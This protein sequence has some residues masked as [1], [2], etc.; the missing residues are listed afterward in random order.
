MTTTITIEQVEALAMQVEQDESTERTRLLRLV[1]A[2]SRILATR[3]PHLYQRM[4][5]AHGDESGHWDGSFPPTQEYSDRRG[6]RLIEVRDHQTSDVAT[7]G[8][9]YHAWRRV[10]ED[11]GLYVDRAGTI[12]GADETGAGRVGQYAAH[13][14]DCDVDCAIEWEPRGLDDVTTDDLRSVE[15]HLRELAFPASASASNVA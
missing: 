10:T 7:E 13:P 9:Y 2:Y 12:Y 6:P 11:A 15:A 4:P 14:G 8:G 3:E 5:L 1:A